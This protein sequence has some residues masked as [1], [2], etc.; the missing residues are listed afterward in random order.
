[1]KERTIDEVE[2]FCGWEFLRAFLSVLPSPMY[3]GFISTLFE[4]GGRIS[5]VLQVRKAN[6]NFNLH[7]CMS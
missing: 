4:T 5:E 7:L 6:F 1:M 2:G 3:Q